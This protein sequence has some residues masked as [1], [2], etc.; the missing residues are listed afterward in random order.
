MAS[1]KTCLLRPL[2]IVSV[3]LV[4]VAQ[5]APFY[6]KPIYHEPANEGPTPGSIGITAKVSSVNN[7]FNLAFPL[8]ANEIFYDKD[9]AVNYHSKGWWG[10]YDLDLS[11]IHTNDVVIG[12]TS[13]SFVEGTDTLK[14]RLSGIDI[15]TNLTGH[16]HCL[17]LIRGDI[18]RLVMKNVTFEALVSTEIFEDKVHWQLISPISFSLG[19]LD[20]TIKQKLWQ[21]IINMAHSTISKAANKFL[22]TFIPTFLQVTIDEFNT[23]LLSDD[24]MTFETPIGSLPMNF[25]MT[26]AMEFRES[27]DMIEIHFDGRFLYNEDGFNPVMPNTMW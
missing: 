5:S 13:L 20:I 26:K 17:G 21:K 19:D 12:S 15:D 10:I 3:L 22:A 7:I 23:M 27:D 24:P 6:F 18:E 25:T 8:A 9:F 14:L 1:Y 2:C 16:V 4:S 11:S